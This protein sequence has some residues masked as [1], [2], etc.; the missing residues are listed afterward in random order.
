LPK[1][2]ST[3]MSASSTRPISIGQEEVVVFIESPCG[4]G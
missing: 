1:P 2:A 3:N 4:L